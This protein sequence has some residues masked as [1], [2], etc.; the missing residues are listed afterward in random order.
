[1]NS[2]S[3]AHR[4][5]S[6]CQLPHLPKPLHRIANMSNR[7]GIK[8]PRVGIDASKQ[9]VNNIDINY[10]FLGH[11]ARDSARID[12]ILCSMVSLMRMTSL[13]NGCGNDAR[14]SSTT[15]SSDISTPR[16]LSCE[17]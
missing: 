5:L 11:P 17:T 7:S 13:L 4:H 2:V 9:D 1:M 12:F 16:G 3:D 10:T 6:F 8:Y 14:I 15:K